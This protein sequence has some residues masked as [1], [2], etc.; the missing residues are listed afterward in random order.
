MAGRTRKFNPVLSEQDKATLEKIVSSRTEEIRKVQRA[1][2]ILL[3]ASGS[4]NTDI[5]NNLGISRPVVNK[6]IKRFSS[7]GVQAALEDAARPGRP[8]ELDPEQQTWIISLACSKPRELPD[9]P[10]LE[11]WTLS[12]L[13]NYVR[14]HCKEHGFDRLESV[15]AST[16]W[17]LLN[18]SEIKPHRIRY[19]LE[20]KDEQF[21]AKAKEVLLLYK[22]IEWITQLAKKY[23][24]PEEEITLV[25]QEVFISYDEKPGI[26]AVENKHKD[27]NPKPGNGFVR[28]DYEYI[29]HGTVSLLA[30]IDLL[31]GKVHSIVCES[32]KSSDFIDFLKMLDKTYPEGLVINIILDNHSAHRSRETMN[33]LATQPNRF[34]F[35]FTPKHASWLNLIESFFGKMAR[36]CLRGL[37]VRSKEALVNHIN[38]W[39]MQVNAEPVIYRWKWK[40]EDIESAFT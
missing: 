18:E 6:I 22:K 32:H 27:R 11:L 39:I 38:R 13:T 17:Y 14:S 2:M 3:A 15:A 37:R 8:K 20:K 31:T 23:D 30:G 10:A 12:A 19:Y 9:G 7:A 36:T 5:A 26:Q 24:D 16:I 1:K 40:L 4:S 21:E 34:K 28:R 33:Y 25:N 29:R 35:T